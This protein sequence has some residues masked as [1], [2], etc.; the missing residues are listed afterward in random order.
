MGL[1]A[2]DGGGGD[3]G[4]GDGGDGGDNG[5]EDSP[6]AYPSANYVLIYSPTPKTWLKANRFCDTEFDTTL[7]SVT[8]PPLSNEAR[9]L[10]TEDAQVNPVDFK[11]AWI[12]LNDLSYAGMWRWIDGVCE[13]DFERFKFGEK[14]KSGCVAVMFYDLYSFVFFFVFF[15]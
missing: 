5:D 2:R 11:G 10:L 12:G 15:V 4:D 6:I 14:S 8:S 3:G 13:G 7:A 1:S 9:N